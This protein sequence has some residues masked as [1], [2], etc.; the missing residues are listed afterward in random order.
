MHMNNILKSMVGNWGYGID[1]NAFLEEQCRIETMLR[2]KTHFHPGGKGTLKP[3]DNEARHSK[4]VDD[5]V[6]HG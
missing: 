2:I 6:G 3:P 1:V 4:V 5:P